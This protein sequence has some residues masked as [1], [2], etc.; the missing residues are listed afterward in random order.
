MSQFIN[1]DSDYTHVNIRIQ[2]D[3]GYNPGYSS[4]SV[5]INSPSR[6]YGSYEA[7]RAIA[8]ASRAAA[9]A[10]AATRS[11][12]SKIDETLRQE[13]LY[14]SQ[15]IAA[16]HAAAQAASHTTVNIY[17]TQPAIVDYPNDVEYIIAGSPDAELP[18]LNVTSSTARA[19]NI[20]SSGNVMVT[21]DGDA[22]VTI[23]GSKQMP[24]LTQPLNLGITSFST[25][26]PPASPAA[27]SLRGR[28]FNTPEQQIRSTRPVSPVR[29]MEASSHPALGGS[30]AGR[31]PLHTGFASRP[32]SSAS[33]A[34]SPSRVNIYSDNYRTKVEYC[35][36]QQQF[37]GLTSSPSDCC[38]QQIRL[39]VTSDGDVN[40]RVRIY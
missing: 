4:T 23:N 25:Y 8:A 13:S 5:K 3:D 30:F 11:I 27:T 2:N 12:R 29:G 20:Y 19:R 38:G 31:A 37:G 28:T 16:A 1:V 7:E 39:H 33:T 21:C 14:R 35:C 9:E 24:T 40:T 32:L 22:D 10:Q 17:S 36:D 26:N 15:R 34:A 18:T 6:S